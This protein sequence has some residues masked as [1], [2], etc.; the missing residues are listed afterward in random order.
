VIAVA[1]GNPYLIRQSPNVS[2]YLVTYGVG[3]ALEHAAAMAVLGR[4][5]IT[6][7]TPVSLPGFFNRGDGIKR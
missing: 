7:T 6:G 5:P 2:T 4:A 1:L 3:D